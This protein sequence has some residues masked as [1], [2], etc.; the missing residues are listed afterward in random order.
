MNIKR[1]V[2][3]LANDKI[4]ELAIAFLNSFRKFNPD[5][6][7]CLIPYDSN[8]KEIA[9][10]SDRY[11]FS[12]FTGNEILNIC[13]KISNRFLDY[14]AG[15]FRKLALWEGP[16]DE[17]IYIDIDTVVL[18]NIEF[19]FQYLSEYDFV[20]SHSNMP[21]TRKWVWK[22]SIYKTN[23]LGIDQIN[24]ATNTGYI[25]SY[26]KALPLKLVTENINAALEL[27]DHMQLWCTEQPLLNYLFVTLGKFTSL[28]IQYCKNPDKIIPLEQ[29]AGRK[30][31]VVKNG[32]IHFSDDNT[33]VL[34]IH[35]AGIY[36]L[37]KLEKWVY[38]KLFKFFGIKK[39]IPVVSFFIPYKR[40]WSYY[41]Y[42]SK[43]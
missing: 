40:L 11:N 15:N 4:Q 13:D 12:I 16:F 2:Y 24:Y 9:S 10:L 35:W 39:E 29:W 5:I 42:Y 3:F 30:Q 31:G 28:F 17:F 41:R 25:I 20:T 33:P 19:C 14:T 18:Q 21:S 7:L 1:G 32:H 8:F 37:T 23:F 34:L 6:P 43:H 26:K 27:K 38:Y 36:R 22:D